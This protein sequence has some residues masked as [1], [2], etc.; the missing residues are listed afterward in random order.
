[1]A[2]PLDR[3]L[4]VLPQ[5]ERMNFMVGTVYS[6]RLEDLDDSQQQKQFFLS[7]LYGRGAPLKGPEAC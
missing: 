1:M 3:W 7:F 4:L 5:R 6:G 2:E